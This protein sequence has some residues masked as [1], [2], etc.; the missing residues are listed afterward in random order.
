MR[1]FSQI[2]IAGSLLWNSLGGNAI[3]LDISDKNSIIAAANLAK[4]NALAYYN[5]YL[6]GNIPGVLIDG[7]YW[8]ECGALMGDL[9]QNWHLT[10]ND[11]LN[12]IITQALLHQMGEH[13]DYEP[14]NWS[15]QLGNDDQV[16]W[17]YAV[18]DA[19]ELGYPNPPED[20]GVSWL[21]LA[22]AVFNDQADSWDPLTCNG[23]LRW[24]ITKVNA[25]YNYKNTISNG[26]F[27]MLASRLARYTGN[28]T[29]HDWANKAFDW[30]IDTPLIQKHSET[31]W[32]ILDGAAIEANCS[33]PVLYQ[34]TYNPGVLLMG[35]AY[36]YNS[37]TSNAS[38]VAKWQQRIDILMNATDIFMVK[39]I[40]SNPTNA[41]MPDPGGLIL[42][43][44]TCETGDPSPCT[45][46]SPAFK[47][48]LAR[49]MAMAAQMAPWIQPRVNSILTTS[50]QAAASVCTNPANP[51]HDQISGS[52][53]SRRWYQNHADGRTGL[54]EQMSALAVFQ[55]LLVPGT[56]LP[57]T[58]TN[59]GNSTSDPGAGGN[60][61]LG[62][63]T[64]DEWVYEFT[65]DA[66]QNAG[67]AILTLLGGSLPILAAVWMVWP[68]G[69]SG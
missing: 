39:P 40:G 20:T 34:W 57:Y 33:Q 53:C 35:A 68:D 64:P 36:L 17:A 54:G 69:R 65:V 46:D 18:M 13:N 1:L 27:F 24:Q 56:A 15:A 4:H 8:W 10:G 19:A 31:S 9:I 5:G 21:G 28:Q 16:F 55:S 49:W 44:V 25:G 45:I 43:E 47:G 22:Q 41:A 26:G 48:F 23:G 42:T 66:G 50:A 63:S 61:I 6:P 52:V 29:Y 11:S 2:A 62:P 14:R 67:A 51:G 59:G 37:T 32:S 38:E 12:E 30:L 3:D 7:Y 60:R 58:A